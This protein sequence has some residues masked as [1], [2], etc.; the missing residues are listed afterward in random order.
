MAEVLLGLA[1]LLLVVVLGMLYFVRTKCP[2]CYNRDATPHLKRKL[3]RLRGLYPHCRS[4]GKP[5][6]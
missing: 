2:H 1:A 3:I 6:G 4:C 5:I